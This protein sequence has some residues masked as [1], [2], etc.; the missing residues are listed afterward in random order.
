MIKYLLFLVMAVS[1]NAAPDF[2]PDVEVKIKGLVCSSCA[3]GVKKGLDKTKLVKKVRFD[4]QKQLCTIEY[5]SIEIHPSQLVKIVKDAGYEV[6][7][8][9]WLKDKKPKRYNKP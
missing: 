4:T 5:V 7:S 2:D 3:I 1:L 9:K 6:S 8:I